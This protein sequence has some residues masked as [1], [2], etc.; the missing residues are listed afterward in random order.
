MTSSDSILDY[1]LAK[2]QHH[3]GKW[4]LVAEGSGVSRR[5]IEKIARSEWE[6]PGVRVIE[7]LARYFRSL[8]PPP[9]RKV[10]RTDR[11]RRSNGGAVRATG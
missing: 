11:R 4:R 7:T 2:L 8:D 3:K 1:V 6:D 10:R 5:S 9:R